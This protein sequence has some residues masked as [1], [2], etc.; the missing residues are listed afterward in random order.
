MN[1]KDVK[2]LSRAYM[3]PNETRRCNGRITDLASLFLNFAPDEFDID[4]VTDIANGAG[5]S[6]EYAYAELFA[7]RFGVD[8]S[9]RDRA[10]FRNYV[11]P[12]F[13]M[14]DVEEY[15]AD[16]YYKNI[17]IPDAKDGAWELKHETLKPAEAFVCRDFIVTEDGRL[18]P[19]LGFFTMPFSFPAVLEGGREWM[20][21]MPNET[22]TT[23]PAIKAA[24]GKVLTYGLGLGY[25]AY[26]ASEKDDVASV[27]VVERDRSVIDLF[28]RHILP[29]FP[30]KEKIDIVRSDA[31]EYASNVAPGEEY[32]FVFADFWHDAG[33]GRD[34]YLKMKEYEKYSQTSEYMYWLEDT[35]L[36]YLDREL[37]P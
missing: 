4:T 27:T 5:V 29:Q 28:S 23:M 35:I 2:S 7:A 25:F 32:D 11:V 19:Q 10:F 34:L 3:S 9:G 30:H 12:M 1:E 13:N 20:T 37:W 21:L 31:F 17:V 8:S 26:M 14:L 36:C 18:I 24:R 16:P 33:D 15:L 22:V 6:C